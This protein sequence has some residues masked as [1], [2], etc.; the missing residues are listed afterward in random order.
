MR[1]LTGFIVPALIVTIGAGCSS[2]GQMAPSAESQQQDRMTQLIEE[3]D[4]TAAQIRQLDYS[5]VA[6]N[7][8]LQQLETRLNDTT[9]EQ[10]AS[11]QE[12]K[13]NIKFTNDQ[14]VRL[15][16]S[17]RSQRTTNPLPQAAEL[18]KP[19]GFDVQ[20]SYQ[21]AIEDYN[22]KRYEAA[23][24][25]FNEIL[26]VSPASSLA[27]NAQYWIG[28]CYYSMGNYDRAL[29]AF[30]RV[31]DHPESNKIAAAHLKIALTRQKMGDADAAR[32]ELNN[33]VRNYP[34]SDESALASRLLNQSGE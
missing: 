20:T 8:R 12:I 4:R 24:S 17:L 28:E 21:A 1:N 11:I 32:T 15:D 13:E 31:F 22:A 2:S 29:D 7:E 14:I 34:G 6:V 23:I 19:G 18:F 25:A 30:G 26:T 33:V 16:N 10:N 3:A 27:D 9:A 5:L